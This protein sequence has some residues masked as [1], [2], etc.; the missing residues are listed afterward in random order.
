MIAR[1]VVRENKRR[2]RTV[3]RISNS[4]RYEARRGEAR[5]DRNKKASEIG[6][7]FTGSQGKDRRTIRGGGSIFVS[8]DIPSL[9]NHSVNC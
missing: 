8:R 2:K 3:G 1:R 6:Q 4:R 5:R 7:R 9:K